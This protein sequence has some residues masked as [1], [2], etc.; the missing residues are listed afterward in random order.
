MAAFGNSV[1]RWTQPAPAPAAK[2]ARAAAKGG[3]RNG[4]GRAAGGMLNRVTIHSEGFLLDSGT[5]NDAPCP[6]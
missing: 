1:N 3:V 5:A 4:P 2:A 6:V